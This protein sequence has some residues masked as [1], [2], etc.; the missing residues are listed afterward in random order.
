MNVSPVSLD[1]VRNA[2]NIFLD[3][4]K[5]EKWDLVEKSG[6]RLVDTQ[7]TPTPRKRVHAARGCDLEHGDPAQRIQD[8]RP[9][10][11]SPPR[12]ALRLDGVL[13]QELCYCALV[14]R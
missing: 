4:I 12:F 5:V 1:C 2:S 8:D 3:I 11:R 9:R 14:V 13:L 6:R 10:G 7:A